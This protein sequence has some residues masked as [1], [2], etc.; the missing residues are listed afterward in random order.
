MSNSNALLAASTVSVGFKLQLD[1]VWQR[2]LPLILDRLAR[3]DGFAAALRRGM[4]SPQEREDA[5]DI[6]HKFSGS[7]GIFGYPTGS[8]IAHALEGLLE[9]DLAP[10]PND[11]KGC[12]QGIRAT[13]N[14]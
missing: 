1:A 12:V 4:A 3:L 11:V 8:R 14:L 6:A 7:L 9:A 13:L 5:L 10:D 2:N